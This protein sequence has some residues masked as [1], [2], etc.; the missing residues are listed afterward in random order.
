MLSNLGELCI[1]LI[2][3]TATTQEDCKAGISWSLTHWRSKQETP[4]LWATTWGQCLHLTS[5][6]KAKPS[7]SDTFFFFY[8]VYKMQCTPQNILKSTPSTFHWTSS[9]WTKKRNGQRPLAPPQGS[10]KGIPTSD[11]RFHSIHR[12]RC[13]WGVLAWSFFSCVST[14]LSSASVMF[15][16]LPL[17]EGQKSLSASLS[18]CLFNTVPDQKQT[19]WDVG[20][21]SYSTSIKSNPETLCKVQI[22]TWTW[23]IG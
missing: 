16:S 6:N 2:Q 15:M 14:T 4:C 3:Y 10:S 13:F 22:E 20:T 11:L 7:S 19:W 21:N 8:K 9:Q 18:L 5:L 17:S 12:L 23:F 1:V